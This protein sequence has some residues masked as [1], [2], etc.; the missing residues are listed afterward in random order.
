MKKII[1][2][3]VFVILLCFLSSPLMAQTA[4]A[5][6]NLVAQ[7]KADRVVPYK[8]TD[9][10]VSKPVIWGLDLAWLSD[11]NIRRGIAFMGLENVGIVRSSFMPTDPLLNDTDLQGLALTNTNLRINILKTYFPTGVDLALNSDHP[12]VDPY[13]YDNAVNWANLIQVTAEMH[14][15]EGFNVVTV[16][17]FNEPDYSATGQGTIQH[18]NNINIELKNRT[19]F[20]DP[21][22]RVSGG[23]TLNNDQAL[24]WYNYLKANLDEGNTHQLAGSFDTYAN[25]FEVVR[26]DGNHATADE[27]HNVMDAMV[28]LE[29]GLQTGIWWGTAEYARGEF[30]RASKNGVRL[31]YAE[32]RYNWTAASVYKTNGKAQA[33]GGVSERQARPTSYNFIS[34]DRAVY[35]DGHGP[36]H[37]F[38]LQLPADPNGAYQTTLQRNAE[39]VI[40]ISWGEDIQP[41]INGEYKLVNRKSGLVLEV[42]GSGNGANVRQNTYSGASN[43]KF[44]VNPV[45]IDIGGDFSYYRIKPLSDSNRSLDVNNFSLD[46]GANIQ[47]WDSA[48]GGNQQWYLDYKDDGWFLIRSR[49]SSFCIDVWN[50]A[51][52]PGANIVQ[53]QEN[54]GFNQEW[55]FLPVDAP[56]EF[57][58]PS[59]PTNLIVTAQA[60]SIKLDWTAS[61]E[62]DVA[63]YT[64]LR[65]ESASGPYNTIARNVTLTS[66]VDNTTQAGVPYYYVVKAED[67][68]LNRSENSNQASA[69][70][71][72]VNALVADYDFEGNTLDSSINLNHCATYTTPAYTTGYIG[73]Q[74]LNFTGSN[75]AQLPADVA[76][77][78]EITVAAWVYR[79]GGGFQQRI[80]DFGN[81]EQEYMYLSPNSAGVGN[82]RFGISIGSWQQEQ[83]LNVPQLPNNSWKHV[84]VTLGSSGV[85]IYVDGVMVGE[86]TGI[87]LNPT[88]FGPVKNY[89]GRSQFNSDSYFIGRIDDFRIYNYELPP[90]Q[91]TSLYNGTLS[92]EEPVLENSV[93]IWPNPANDVLHITTRNHT[94]SSLSMFDLNGRMI[95]HQ[96]VKI[97]P[98]ID[99]DISNLTSG[100]YILKLNTD[101]AES[102]IKKVV[103]RH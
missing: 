80:F 33:F 68:S 55:R 59:A 69:T 81:G 4:S 97:T 79:N 15:N 1:I 90:E 39:R 45:P 78:Q 18:F 31:A 48:N 26:A 43:Q 73:S 71:T 66:F 9:P 10:G 64:I 67:N 75:F 5:S 74:A 34:K 30:C 85:R 22:I 3:T 38:V 86:N 82:M 70:A 50:A 95:L 76:N 58:A 99:F 23:N 25:F 41:A 29:Y 102:V 14:M 52:N 28:G 54:G 103:I 94:F 27:M 44:N 51:V 61:P 42:N 98:N 32:H 87:T 100:I 96:N 12:S 77:Y 47:L 63:G 84:A 17:P 21:L 2:K 36:Q 89:I 6:D 65:G 101:N 49:E 19:F 20:T 57:V 83:G 8:I 35:Y 53:W 72:G 91:I 16:S 40:N 88:D 24:Y 56:I 13:F 11:R 93:T 92:T 7:P 62:N 60:E 46:N 37:E